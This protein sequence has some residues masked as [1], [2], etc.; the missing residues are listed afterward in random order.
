[1]LEYEC[2]FDLSLAFIEYSNDR[3][4]LLSGFENFIFWFRVSRGNAHP[5]ALS[6]VVL[7]INCL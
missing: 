5:A 4:Q 7:L 3:F 6:L 1:M 2:L